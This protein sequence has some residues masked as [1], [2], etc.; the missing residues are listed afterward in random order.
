MWKAARYLKQHH[1][2]FQPGINEDLAAT[3]V[4]ARSR[5]TCSRAPSTTAC[6]A[7]GNGKG[8]GVDRCG[9]VFK[10]ANA[11]GTSRHGGVLVV[12]GDDH[13]AKSSTLPHQS[14]HIQGLHDPGAVSRQ[15]AGSAGLRPAWLGHEPLCRGVGR[16]EMH[17]RHRRGVRLGGGQPE[18]TRIVLPEDFQ[19]PPDGLNIRLPDTPLQQEA[20]LLDYKLYAALA[21]ARANRLNRECGRCPTRR[22]VSAS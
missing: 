20:R 9:D 14:D 8:P 6:S 12:A 3:A 11:A 17:H 5:S 15:R 2:E 1:I 10:H 13:P 7:C 16:H 19:P 18:R 22:R 21:Y 4:W